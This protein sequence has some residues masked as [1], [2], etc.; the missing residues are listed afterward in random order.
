MDGLT[1]CTVTVNCHKKGMQYIRM[2]Q[3]LTGHVSGD[4]CAG[5]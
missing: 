1:S 4:N 3:V 5:G 2:R